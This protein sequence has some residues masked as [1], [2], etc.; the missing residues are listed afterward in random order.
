MQKVQCRKN[1]QR[2]LAPWKEVGGSLR[3]NS[4]PSK[5]HAGL[6]QGYKKSSPLGVENLVLLNVAD[7]GEYVPVS[8]N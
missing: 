3:K 8:G 4:Q 1:L 7:L 5:N 6:N 2:S